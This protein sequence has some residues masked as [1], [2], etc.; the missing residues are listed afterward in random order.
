MLYPAISAPV[1]DLSQVR[2][3][4]IGG[5]AARG[6]YT[7]PHAFPVLCEEGGLDPS[8]LEM[9]SGVSVGSLLGLA[10]Y[11]DLSAQEWWEFAMT[12]KG[13]Q[14]RDSSASSSLRFSAQILD[15]LSSF[16]WEKGWFGK[17][18]SILVKLAS[19]LCLGLSSVFSGL[20]KQFW[21]LCEGEQ[22]ADV[23]TRLIQNK[24]GLHKP[25]FEALNAWK[26]EK[27]QPGNP[28]PIFRCRALDLITRSIKHFDVNETP[29]YEVAQAIRASSAI[30]LFFAP[31][32]NRYI[33]GGM[34]T[35]VPLGDERIQQREE[36]LCVLFSKEKKHTDNQQEPIKTLWDFVKAVFGW[37]VTHDRNYNRLKESLLLFELSSDR[38]QALNFSPA[39]DDRIIA[40]EDSRAKTQRFLKSLRPRTPPATPTSAFMDPT[41]QRPPELVGVA[42]LTAPEM[43]SAAPLMS[44]VRVSPV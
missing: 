29:K 23:T 24:T 33:D 6:A 18:F 38:V 42:T 4:L 27:T 19:K 35:N 31:V 16:L 34:F 11:L 40:G 14:L 36:T 39:M 1:N 2:Q 32:E 15:V 26:R 43:V 22:L 3:L 12:F 25:T 28:V 30:P 17:G 44:P 20:S 5:G 21:G 9:I 8:K 10:V 41:S 37:F 7:F 13:E